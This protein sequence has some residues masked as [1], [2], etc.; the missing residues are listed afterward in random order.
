MSESKTILVYADWREL[1]GPALVGKLRVQNLRGKEVFDFTYADEWVRSSHGTSIDPDLLLYS[2]PQYVPSGRTNFGVFLD[3]S[4][5]RWG[6]T[7][8][9]RRSGGKL[10]EVDYTRA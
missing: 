9:Q 6:R 8:M 7:L 4:P 5:D 10:Y 3:S 2:G 1:D